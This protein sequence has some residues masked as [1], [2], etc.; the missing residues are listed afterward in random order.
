MEKELIL[1]N[2]SLY[3]IINM[4]K[5]GYIVCLHAFNKKKYF[6]KKETLDEIKDEIIVYINVESLHSLMNEDEWPWYIYDKGYVEYKSIDILPINEKN[7][8]HLIL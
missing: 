2:N 4:L 1:T 6:Y 5:N 8:H 7:I 3:D